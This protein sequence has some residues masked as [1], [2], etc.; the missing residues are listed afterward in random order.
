VLVTQRKNDAQRVMRER[1]LEWVDFTMSKRELLARLLSAGGV[2]PIL[3]RIARRP[4]LLVLTYHRVGSAAESRFDGGVYSATADALWQQ[5]KYVR[6]K[7]DVLD[8]ERLLEAAGRNFTLDR[9]SVAIT[10]DD[11]YREDLELAVSMLCDARVPA[12]FF[13]PSDC[14]DNPRL[15]WWDRIALILK[16]TRVE[17]L[18][19]ESPCQIQIDVRGLGRDEAIL[20][21]LE[22]YKTADDFSEHDFF[23]QLEERAQVTV[24]P[25][26]EARDLFVSWDQVRRMRDAGMAIGSHTHRHRVL[27]RLS[28]AEQREELATSKARLE[29]ELGKPVETIAY[30]VGTRESFSELTKSLAREVGYQIGFS[31]YGGINRPGRTDPFNIRRIPVDWR[32]TFRVFRARAVFCNLASYSL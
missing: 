22:L 15:P 18:C 8:E 6:A 24:H 13:I 19:L 30:P 16:Q 4:G 1:P 3:E 27:A 2:L 31:Y 9:P 5:I 14:V 11:G 21:L 26:A 7:F 20:Q 17:Q 12:F 32:D 10:F 29:A 28:E 23:N 25:E